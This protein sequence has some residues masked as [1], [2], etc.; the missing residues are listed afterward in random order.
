MSRRANPPSA[1]V[2]CLT[3]AAAL[4]GTAAGWAA[5][6]PARSTLPDLPVNQ[7]EIEAAAEGTLDLTEPPAV[8]VSSAQPR[9]PRAM[10]TRM[11]DEM[12]QA[13]AA[14]QQELA[15][16]TERFNQAVDQDR[17]LAIQREIETLKGNIEVSFLEIQA[18]YAREAGLTARADELDGIVAQ[19]RAASQASPEASA[20]ST[21]QSELSAAQQR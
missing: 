17:A 18:R 14:Y 12:N 13:K 10:V 2:F 7:S 3:L 6:E 11:G 1:V 4:S 20:S 8:L 9:L 21:G 16:L 5:D 15:R 19:I